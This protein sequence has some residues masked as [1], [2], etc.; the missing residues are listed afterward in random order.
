MKDPT[1]PFALGRPRYE[2]R[3]LL[4]AIMAS[5]PFL[6]LILAHVL[7]FRPGP[8]AGTAW[9]LVAVF[10]WLLA[11]RWMQ[12]GIAYP[13]R[14]VTTLLE[15]LREGD[16]LLRGR[17]DVPGD[18]LG[19]VIRE[20]NLLRDTLH[21]QRLKVRETV[22]LLSK[23]LDTA[24]LAVFTFG[25]DSRLRLTN[26]AGRRLLGEEHTAEE[27]LQQL[28]AKQLGLSE[29]L[30]QPGPF[31]S[32]REFSGQSG[33]W[34]V[35]HRTFIEGGET[36]HLLVLSDLSRALRE[37]ERLAWQRLIRVLGHEINNSLA[38]IRSLAEV[39]EMR[40]KKIE[41]PEP[42]SSE[43]QEA[44]DLI[45]SRADSLLRF[46]KA[47]T[48]LA[49]LPEPEKQVINLK[50]LVH[51]VTLLQDAERVSYKGPELTIEADPAQL[52]QL[53][54]NLVKNAL[55]ALEADRGSVTIN[56]RQQEHNVHIEVLDDGHGLPISDNLFVPFFTTKTGGSGIGL[57]L[58]RR[59][60]EA[61]GGRL[62]LSNRDSGGCR[63]LLSLPVSSSADTYTKSTSRTTPR[64]SR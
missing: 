20:V 31:I 23:V 24:D 30:D 12:R 28:D 26:Q 3:A 1:K 55:E 16:Y 29:F 8:A 35:R 49:R 15:A 22:A 27:E 52:E 48:L 42:M 59:I 45:G 34:E 46:I 57:V 13:L 44:I 56:W 37:E 50:E 60:A 5:L 2:R 47:Y 32:D 39:M 61:H 33:R 58:C 10:F 6:L 7:G 19:E 62:A 17:L 41:L 25:P 54:I 38:P 51:R 43:L 14:T 18:A 9:F 53:L 63:A 40:L 64:A 21:Q 4:A 11:L 36:H